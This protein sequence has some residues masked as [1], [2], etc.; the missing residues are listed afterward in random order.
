MLPTMSVAQ[1]LQPRLIGGSVVQHITDTCY[2]NRGFVTYERDL[3]ASPVAGTKAVISFPELFVGTRR[4]NVGWDLS[5]Q[6]VLTFKTQDSGNINF[7]HSS[8]DGVFSNYSEEDF[9]PDGKAEVSFL[10]TTERGNC[11]LPIDIRLQR[12][13]N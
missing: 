8:L 7:I 2:V 9:G 3:R 11:R 12:S 4:T 5:G 1:S 6:A 10:L 13:S